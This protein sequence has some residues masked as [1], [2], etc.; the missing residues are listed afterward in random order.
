[1]RDLPATLGPYRLL[2]RL[3]AGGMGEVWAAVDD[4]LGRSVALKRIRSDHELSSERRERFQE[5]AR[6]AARLNHPGIVQL[7]DV[8]HHEGEHCLVFELVEGQTLRQVLAAGPLPMPRLGSLARQLAA[9]LEHAHA[10]GVVHRDLKSENVLLTESGAVKIADFGIAKRLAGDGPDLTATRKVV[11]TCRSMSPE[12]ARGETVDWRSDLFSLGVLLY[13]AATGTS[14]FEAENDLATLR[15]LQ[16]EAHRPIVELR[17]D[18]PPA[19]AELIDH[20]LEKDPL[21]RPQSAGEVADAL[22]ELG[23]SSSHSRT[24]TALELPAAPTPGGPP[25][26]RLSPWL[27]GLGAAALVAAAIA[28]FGRAGRD[29]GPVYVAVPA[30]EIESGE[31]A[32][33]PELLASAVRFAASSSL[34]SLRSVSVL[35]QAEVDSSPGTLRARAAALGADE[36]LASRLACRELRCWVTLERVDGATGTVTVS[37]RFEVPADD[38]YV[39]SQVVAAEVRQS[40]KERRV[41]PGALELA[42]RPEDFARFLK[43]DHDL[44]HAAGSSRAALLGEL[45]EVRSGSPRFV[46]AYLLAAEI[47]RYRFWETR[48]AGDLDAALELLEAARD[49]DPES[50]RPFDGLL[51]L[52]LDTGDFGRAEIALSELAAREPGSSQLKAREAQLLLA[53]GETRRALELMREATDRRPT[54]SNLANLATME[55]NA[56]DAAAAR[57]RLEQA[58]ALAPEDF[59]LGSQLA[60]IELLAGDTSRAAALYQELVTREGGSTELSNLGLA[61]LLLGRFAE[62]ADA[63]E[64]AL[65]LA[66]KNVFMLLNLADA[67]WLAGQ[68]GAA[69]ELYEALLERM[70]E[71]PAPP[72]W[73][74]STVRGQALAHLGRSKE[75]VAAIAEAQRLAPDNS[76]VAYE[77]AL[78]FALAGDRNSALVQAERAL[79]LGYEARWFNFPWFAPLVA[80]PG[81]AARLAAASTDP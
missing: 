19:F 25:W 46:A 57:R 34:L 22:A 27:V 12:Q 38:V 2:H 41:R 62:A 4:R 13:E 65:A 28:W 15:R 10:K 75:A 61:L 17:P 79:D 24:A 78:V 76:Q 39:L 1:M 18:L 53:R 43:V 42:V 11:G 50:S 44:R 20:L 66:P 3:G 16:A 77:S 5:E 54:R 56:G 31:R 72:S 52:A 68:E 63:F 80:E 9:A 30:A 7:Y 58:L 26:R 14:P 35:P 40:F 73:Q 59:R 51:S 33:Q 74:R 6:T 81:F 55:L 23:A 47:L 60:M 49:L 69:R 70:E 48:E 32:A 64:Q 8:L 67:R 37:R 29:A 45:A 36:I 21:L 71:T